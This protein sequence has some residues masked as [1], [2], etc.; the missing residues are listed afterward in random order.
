VSRPRVVIAGGGPVGLAL[1]ASLT[2][3]EVHVIEGA[4]KRS[5]PWPEEFDVRVYAVSPGTR[6]FLRDLGAWEAL[7]ARRIA[8]V[9]RMEIFGDEDAR[10]AFSA[11]PG[12]ALAWTVEAGRL[13]AAIE[14]VVEGLP[15]VTLHRGASAKAFGADAS[16]AW[17]ELSGGKRIEGD[18]LVGADGPASRVRADMKIAFEEEAYGESAIIANFD[19]EK[20]HGGVARQWFRSDGVLAWLPLPG[21]RVSIVWST[22]AANADTLMA[23]APQDL[24]QRV[25]DAGR[26][27][28]GELR[29]VSTTGRFELRS[30][31]VAEPV[32]AGVALVGDAAHAVHPLAG[33]GVNL[34]FQD[35]RLLAEV[36]ASRSAVERPGDLRVLRRYARERREDVTAMHFVTDGLDKLF[37]SG[38]PGLRAFRNLGLRLMDAQP[39]AKAALASR[40]MR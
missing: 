12:A 16:H 30:V 14:S 1:A 28:L 5:E 39:W 35:A 26:A 25:R 4:V 10:L 37:A 24:E 20:E 36:L 29:L 3:F 7:D 17:A 40:A 31:R 15:H 13:A 6:D 2:G 33:Q 19:V 23:L 8:S 34:G 38:S 21:K 9:R 22:P 11:R 32:A 18:L 27:E